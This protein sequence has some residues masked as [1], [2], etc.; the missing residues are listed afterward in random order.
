M[1]KIICGYSGIG[2]SYVAKQ[3]P[4]IVLDLESSNY[5][6]DKDSWPNNYVDDIITYSKEF[7]DDHYILCSCHEEVRLEL[8]NRGVSFVIVAPKEELLYEYS[9]RWYKR[10]SSISFIKKMQL[11]WA[12][13][14]QS[15]HKHLTD[16]VAVILLDKDEYVGDLIYSSVGKLG[17]LFKRHGE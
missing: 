1:A 14:H 12:I 17:I 11:N 2:K 13:M 5:S 3:M 10:G 16:R 15:I 8:E 4:E 7:D 9:K 6:K